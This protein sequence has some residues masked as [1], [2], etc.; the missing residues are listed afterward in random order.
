MPIN[1]KDA[2]F[3]AIG[4]GATNDSPAIQRAIDYAK[5]RSAPGSPATIYRVTVYFPAG[6]YYLASPINL[7][8]TNGI[9]LTGDGGSYLNTIIFGSTG[10]A[11]F[12]FSGSSLS[13]CENFSFLTSDRNSRSTI[14][15]LFALTN[16]GG[17]SCGIRHCYFE[18]NDTPSANGG[19]GSIGLLNI[20]SEEFFI[21][22]CLIRANTSVIFSYTRDLSE[23]GTSFT[24]SSSFQTLSSGVG[25]MGVVD[26]TGTSLQNYEKRQP[27][28][29]LLGTNSLNFQGYISR[30][31]ASAGTNETAILCVRYTV[32]LRI[33][34]TIESF[35]RVLKAI[36][37]GFE[38]NELKVVLANNTSPATELIDV[39]NCGVKGFTCQISLPNPTERNRLVMYHAPVGGGTQVANGYLNNSVIT[40]TDITDNRNVISQNLLRRA[41]NVQFNSD[42]AFEKKGGRI[43]Q[44]FT[45]FIAIGQT[46][47]G[48]TTAILRFSLA[49]PTTINNTNGG[50]YRIWIDGVVEAGSYGTQA[51]ATLSFQAQLLVTQSYNGL[52]SPTSVTVVILDRTTTNAA[53]VDIVGIT[54]DVAFAN[55][56][57]SV[58]LTPRTI[59]T[60]SGDPI[61]YNGS[62]ELQSNFLANDS[63]IFR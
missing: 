42:Q 40:C 36:L 56:I 48:S 25:S 41:D 63:V 13:G 19:F 7:T 58:L 8:N 26:I 4:D 29:V 55:G 33:L 38:N 21:H 24:V 2:Q 50:S 32:N 1:V 17:L 61:T 47:T 15:V 59:G 54:V 45:S 16:N 34:A 22:E 14:G 6:Y 35:S 11:I 12:D 60:S 9:W 57:G 30:L 5:T 20:R 51:A 18:M 10:G 27:A 44:L 37:G 46:P 39:T 62:A 31:T 23:T 3:G 28:M 49:S 53:Y 52:F 43:R